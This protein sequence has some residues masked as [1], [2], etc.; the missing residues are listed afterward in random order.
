ME[1]LIMEKI[2]FIGVGIMGKPTMLPNSPHVK[3][4]VLGKNGVIEG[5]RKG[6]ILIDMSSIAPLVSQEIAKELEKKGL[7]ILEL[8]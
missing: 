8:R 2:G 5:V 7:E 1:E 6:Q 4:V 3:E